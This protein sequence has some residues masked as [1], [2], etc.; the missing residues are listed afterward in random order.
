[1]NQVFHHIGLLVK[2]HQKDSEFVR[3]CVLFLIKQGKKVQVLLH[4]TE[5]KMVADFCFNDPAID[6]IIIYGGDGT[7]LSYARNCN[8]SLP[9]LGI[10]GGSLGWLS[11]IDPAKEWKKEMK[12]II[13]GDYQLINKFILSVSVE[14][15]G[16]TVLKERAVNDAVVNN[17]ELSRII[18]IEAHVDQEY[19]TEYRADGL[20]VSTPTGS[21]AYNLSAGGPILYPSLEGIIITP[22][23]PQSLSQRSVVI[24]GDKKVLLSFVKNKHLLRLTL[25]GQRVFDLEKDDEV[26]I[27]LL[28]E[29]LQLIKTEDYSF[30]EMLG[31]KLGWGR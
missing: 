14:R 17:R 1:M 28:A 27:C 23:S 2:S 8:I 25:D 9:V 16:K 13:R 3:A 24:P 22:I 4:D 10:N 31:Q 19:L 7:L 5:D 15:N 18:S 12:K 26:T 21:T 6:L 11:A 30:F 20:I 29:K